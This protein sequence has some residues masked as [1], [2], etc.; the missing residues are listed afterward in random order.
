MV[1]TGL[2]YPDA[3]E[4]GLLE[5]LDEHDLGEKFSAQ[6]YYHLWLITGRSDYSSSAS[7]LYRKFYDEVR[8]TEYLEK[9]EEL[10][11]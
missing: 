4:K 9:L 8:N 2:E 6:V 11:A 1:L 7:V 3:A 5:L 10:E